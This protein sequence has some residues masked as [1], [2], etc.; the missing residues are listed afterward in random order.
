M[1]EEGER[2]GRHQ[3]EECACEV[4]FDEE[5]RERRLK[6]T[7]RG[8]KGGDCVLRSCHFHELVAFLVIGWR[9]RTIRRED[10]EELLKIEI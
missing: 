8:T 3:R 10:Q 2:R 7:T 6:P 5:E 1:E 9:V 4:I